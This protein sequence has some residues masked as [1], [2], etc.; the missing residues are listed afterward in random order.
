ME[1][2]AIAGPLLAL[3]VFKLAAR[4]LWQCKWCGRQTSVTAG[5]VL[6]RTRLPLTVW[7]WAAYL[8]STHTP[9]LS[10]QLQRQLGLS[11]ESAWALLH[12]LRRAVVNPE[13]EPLQDKVECR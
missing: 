4:G 12:K 8:V 6:H 3:G 2:I 13:R 9:G 10:V 11:Y 1:T 5:T 7:F